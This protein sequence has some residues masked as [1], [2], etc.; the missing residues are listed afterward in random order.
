MVENIK[1]NEG[2]STL[3][4]ISVSV[5][6]GFSVSILIWI[7]SFILSRPTSAFRNFAL[8]PLNSI[9]YYTIGV[10]VGFVVFYFR[11]TQPRLFLIISITLFMFSIFLWYFIQEPFLAK[12]LLPPMSSK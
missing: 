4:R 7:I 12:L 2:L 5:L 10:V 9:P 8:H 11:K 3:G 1:G 6:L